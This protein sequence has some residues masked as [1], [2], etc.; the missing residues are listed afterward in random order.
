MSLTE[1]AYRDRQWRGLFNLRNLLENI[2]H[3]ELYEFVS[4]IDYLP[5]ERLRDLLEIGLRIKWGQE[6]ILK[7]L[8]ECQATS[9][10]RNELTHVSE[11]FFEV[12]RK[13]KDDAELIRRI[14]NG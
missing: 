6:L 5:E 10:L 14:G 2:E 11:M 9:E 7:D 13:I 1:E 12:A 8:E 4:S 3:K